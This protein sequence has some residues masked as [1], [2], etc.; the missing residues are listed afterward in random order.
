[1]IVLGQY[2]AAAFGLVA[3]YVAYFIVSTLLAK[4]RHARNARELGCKEPYDRPYRLPLAYDLIQQIQKAD[5][6]HVVPSHF[7]E[8]YNIVGKR[9]TWRQNFLGTHSIVTTD[10]KNIQALLATQFTD[11]EIGSTRRNNFFPMF[12]NGIFTVD[13]KAWYPPNPTH[14]FVCLRS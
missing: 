10:P 8:M 14:Q 2:V 3:S 7:L 12:G 9:P 6:E 5:V 1:M 4:R 11:F 13:G